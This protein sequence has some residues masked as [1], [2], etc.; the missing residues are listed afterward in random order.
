MKLNKIT[1]YLWEIPKSGEIEQKKRSSYVIF[2]ALALS[3]TILL[4]WTAFCN[5][6]PLVYYDSAP[7][8]LSPHPLRSV[9][10][11]Y[12]LKF[13]TW[14][15]SLWP[16][17]FVQSLIT[18]YLL[19]RVSCLMLK[20]SRHKELI[21]FALIVLLAALTDISKYV[22]WI[23]PDIFTGWSLLG[24]MIFFLSHAW[25]D[26]LFA[27]IAIFLSLSCHNSHIVI[28]VASFL[29]LGGVGAAL[30]SKMPYI[31]KTAKQLTLLILISLIAI[32]ALDYGVGFDFNPC[33]PQKWRFLFAKFEHYGILSGTLK[34]YCPVKKWK[35]CALADELKS[36][37]NLAIWELM[38]TYKSPAVKFTI[39]ENQK[40]MRKEMEEVLW[41]AFICNPGTVIK[42]SVTDTL[43]L[44]N[45]F[46][47]R[48]GISMDTDAMST[49][50]HS[51][52]ERYPNELKYFLGGRQY[53]YL[54][55]RFRMAPIDD[56]FFQYC[57][58]SYAVVLAVLLFLR[59]QYILLSN[60]AAV[61]VYIFLNAL[62]TASISVGDCERYNMRVMWLMP[63]ILFLATVIF[64]SRERRSKILLE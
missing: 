55:A 48:Y 28:A 36:S 17:I 27:G 13:T 62:V 51:I 63:Y 52:Q 4:L 42:Y 2:H 35:I 1:D 47:T 29:V 57:V 32:S 23:M 3:S 59:K 53:N 19:M 30:K 21:A 58:L 22:C 33:P 16:A 39:Y 43:I 25:Y 9:G 10:Y 54:S 64:I 41:Y 12:F 56:R 61:A 24:G 60:I 6:Y 26:R 15:L 49:I 20:G 37:E 31:W 46:D 8:M 45:S 34:K 5:K 11:F 14:R 38:W 7:Y 44:L 40:E 50:R 18:S